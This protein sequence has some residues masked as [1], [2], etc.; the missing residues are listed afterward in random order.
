MIVLLLKFSYIII[1]NTACTEL[2]SQTIINIAEQVRKL[3]VYRNR[4]TRRYPKNLMGL[5]AKGSSSLF[6]A[7]TKRH[8]KSEL[9]MSVTNTRNGRTCHVFVIVSLPKDDG[10]TTA[11]A[12]KAQQFVVD[13]T[14]TQF[15]EFSNKNVVFLKLDAAINYPFYQSKYV[16]HSVKELRGHQ[17]LQGW[18]RREIAF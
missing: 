16:Y 18:C 15:Q 12:T 8:Y 2:M 11:A 3:L 13:I 6:R 7:L 14:A 10:N 5:C 1:A 17:K 9:R 4:K